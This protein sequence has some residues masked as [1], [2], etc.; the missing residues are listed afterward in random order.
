[1]RGL[2]RPY[3]ARMVAWLT[4]LFRGE[5]PMTFVFSATL[6]EATR[7]G[8]VSAD[9]A[10]YTRLFER[11]TAA[12]KGTPSWDYVRGWT[13]MRVVT[14]GSAELSLGD[15]AAIELDRVRL[16]VSFVRRADHGMANYTVERY[17]DGAPTYGAKGRTRSGYQGIYVVDWAK[18]RESALLTVEHHELRIEG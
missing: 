12:L 14:R 2:G 3:D 15:S 11:E 5:P 8:G 9:A 17:L 10:P 7:G 1:M 18:E 13:G 4:R 16:V 6:L